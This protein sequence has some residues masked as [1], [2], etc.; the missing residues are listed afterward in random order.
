MN[1]SFRLALLTSVLVSAASAQ[2]LLHQWRFGENDPGAADFGLITT[3]TAQVGGNTLTSTGTVR[4]LANTPGVASSLSAAFYTTNGSFTGNTITSLGPSSSF[5]MEGWFSF[6]G[7]PATGTNV[8]F[9]NG[10][11]SST[12]LGLYVT[13]ST[14]QFLRGGQGDATV[15][16]VNVNHWNYVAIVYDNGQSSVYLNGATTPSYSGAVSFAGYS[17]SDAS[18]KFYIGSGFLGAVDE[19]RV[20]SFSGSFST[21]MLSYAS[22]SAVPEPSTYAALAGLA[23]LGLV[24]SRRRALRV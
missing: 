1:R 12:G 11:P 6:D 10:N 23:A 21:S 8:L 24:A 18:E 7:T 17:G 3:T 20:S 16:T 19:L 14:L 13:G 22:I 9:Y 2:T 4:Y 15:G 5:I